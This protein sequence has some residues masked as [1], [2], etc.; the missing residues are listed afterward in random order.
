M[1]IPDRA[2]LLHI[3]EA[4]DYINQF[5]IGK[6]KQDLYDD[7][8]LRFAVERQLEVIGE[9]ANHLS[10]A[11]KTQYSTVEWRKITAFRNFII[12]EYFGIDLELVWSI[13]QTNIAP[14]RLT[15]EEILSSLA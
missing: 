11:L 9:A 4:I 10:D 2:R 5:L 12:H 13:T 1:P 7:A 8:L 14:L 6:T 3:L 15:I